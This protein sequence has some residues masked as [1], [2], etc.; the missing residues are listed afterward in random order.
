M[1]KLT[2]YPTGDCQ[3]PVEAR[4]QVMQLCGGIVKD[5]PAPG[6]LIHYLEA[7]REEQATHEWI[8]RGYNIRSNDIA[9]GPEGLDGLLADLE[10]EPCDSC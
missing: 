6:Q 4:R 5:G 7:V 3:Y 9:L 10:R 1:K 2:L 8:R